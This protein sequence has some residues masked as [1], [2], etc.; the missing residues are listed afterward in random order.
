M[1]P[2]DEKIERL[3]VED[4]KY[5]VSK[6]EELFKDYSLITTSEEKKEKER[7]YNFLRERNNRR[8]DIELG[9]D[10]RKY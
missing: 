10:L 6:E 8:A 9:I 5:R 4:T 1:L 3:K 7:Y 2:K